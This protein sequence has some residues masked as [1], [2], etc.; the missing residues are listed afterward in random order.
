ML[1]LSLSLWCQWMAGRLMPVAAHLAPLQ[2]I[3]L[4][5]FLPVELQ[6]LAV[7]LERPQLV[8]EAEHGGEA[9][10]AWWR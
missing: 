3:E 5:L 8:E 4:V 6:V 10:P 2:P 1:G 9:R 7:Q